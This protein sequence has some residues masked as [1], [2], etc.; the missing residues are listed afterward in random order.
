M[1][2]IFLKTIRKSGTSLAINIPKEI[3]DILDIKDGDVVRIAIEK[4]VKNK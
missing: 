3:I 2:E 4:Q 1:K